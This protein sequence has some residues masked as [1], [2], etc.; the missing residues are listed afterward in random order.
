V[1]IQG[2]RGGHQASAQQQLESGSVLYCAPYQV[3][4]ADL[5][6][7]PLVNTNCCWAC[8]TALATEHQY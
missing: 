6:Q 3:S 4:T 5:P 7:A 2:W 8:S 1:G